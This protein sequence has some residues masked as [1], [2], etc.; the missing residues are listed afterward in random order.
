MGEETRLRRR[1]A[2]I[3]QKELAEQ[4]RRSRWSATEKRIRALIRWQGARHVVL[5]GIRIQRALE[6][7]AQRKAK[8]DAKREEALQAQITAMK[9]EA[10]SL[11]S[12]QP[13]QSDVQIEELCRTLSS[14][15]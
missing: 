10:K 13:R 6:S 3:S 11:L 8:A 5:G 9:A 7:S 2:S 15:S 4:R 12:N 1:R 14:G